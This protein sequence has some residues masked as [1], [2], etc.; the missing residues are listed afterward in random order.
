MLGTIAES[1]TS[2]QSRVRYPYYDA[3]EWRKELA[4]QRALFERLGERVPPGL[5]AVQEAL[6]RRLE[7]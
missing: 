6:A 4:S 7:A 2:K 1:K 5:R 3:A